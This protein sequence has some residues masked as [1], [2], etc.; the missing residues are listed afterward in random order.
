M[1][2]GM[3]PGYQRGRNEEQGGVT[4]WMTGWFG[5]KGAP[6]AP[7]KPNHQ[8]TPGNSFPGLLV[9][10]LKTEPQLAFPPP[11]L[12]AHD[13]KPPDSAGL[14]TGVRKSTTMS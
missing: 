8:S 12:P 3:Q 13:T 4:G 5:P 2:D 1:A 9:N 7:V 11:K 6:N 10:I 14:S